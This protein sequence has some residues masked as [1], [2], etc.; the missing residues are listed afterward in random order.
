M[1][2]EIRKKERE[3]SLEEAKKII[4][5]NNYGVLSTINVDNG[6][7]YGIPLSYSYVNDEIYFHSAVE[8]LK[9][10]AFGRDSRVCFTVIG[11]TEILPDKFSTKY[12]SAIIYGKILELTE[13]EKEE[14]LFELIKKYSADFLEEGKKY[15]ERSGARTKVFK[16]KIEHISGKARR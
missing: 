14:A 6:Y 12:E 13:K 2:R 16:I 5:E 8:G 10:E 3:I 11:R 4:D 1:F 7:P 9:V 15:I